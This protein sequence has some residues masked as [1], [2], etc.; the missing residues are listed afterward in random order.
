MFKVLILCLF[1]DICSCLLSMYGRLLLVN[2]G[3]VIAVLQKSLVVRLLLK[4]LSGPFR[5]LFIVNSCMES[6]LM[7]FLYGVFQLYAQSSK[8]KQWIFTLLGW[9]EMVTFR[10]HAPLLWKKGRVYNSYLNSQSIIR[11]YLFFYYLSYLTKS[12][13][14]EFWSKS[15]QYPL[16]TD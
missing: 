6:G 13:A 1:L 3:S 12:L 4:T 10:F 7:S 5:L 14:L 9:K 8:K 2:P 15:F 11:I 16:N